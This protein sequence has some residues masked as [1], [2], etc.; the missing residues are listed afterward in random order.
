MTVSGGSFDW[1]IENTA[2][3]WLNSTGSST[4]DEKLCLLYHLEGLEH[5]FRTLLFELKNSGCNLY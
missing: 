3:A 1:F 5:S 4:F 2:Q